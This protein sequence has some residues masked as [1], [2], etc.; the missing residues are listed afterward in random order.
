MTEARTASVFTTRPDLRARRCGDA[1]VRSRPATAHPGSYRPPQGADARR[2][3]AGGAVPLA[4]FTGTWGRESM[5][6][7]LHQFSPSGYA[8]RSPKSVVHGLRQADKMPR[9]ASGAARCTR[10]ADASTGGEGGRHQAK[11]G[12]PG[13][14]YGRYACWRPGL[15]PDRFACGVDSWAV[16]PDPAFLRSALLGGRQG[17]VPSRHRQPPTR[18][19]PAKS[20]AAAHG[21]QIKKRC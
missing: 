11:G 1:P 8:V 9:T 18:G 3:Q 6:H 10:P 16:E 21:R 20:V 14:S 5:A 17:A 7:G 12:D 15:P 4:G 19:R 2:R 13:G